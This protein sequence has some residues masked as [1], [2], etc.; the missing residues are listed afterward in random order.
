[1]KSKQET[2]DSLHK[3]DSDEDEAIPNHVESS[4]ATDNTAL[5]IEAGGEM[6]SVTPLHAVV[7]AAN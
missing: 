7:A 3:N 6:A 1:M 4:H 2:E 5:D